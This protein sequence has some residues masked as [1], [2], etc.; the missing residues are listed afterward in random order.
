MAIELADTPKTDD[1]AAELERLIEEERQRFDVP[2]VAVAVVHGG[3]VVL[4]RGFGQRDLAKGLPVTDQT[5]FAIGSSTKAFTASLCGAL[6][7]DGLL[8]WDRPVRHYLP[9][10]R[11]HD[12]VATELLTV[13]DMLS[14][15]SGLP[16]HDMLWYGNEKLRREELVERLPHLEPN[17]T[18]R[19]LWQ[20]NNLMYVT[21]GYLAGELMGCGW[22]EAVRRRLLQPSG[23]GGTNFSVLESQQAPDHAL[24]HAPT[25]AGLVEVPFRGLDLAGPAGPL[26]PSNP[27]PARGGGGQGHR[28]G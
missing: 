25:A 7:D 20:Y 1:K 21:A 24:P 27:R 17:K 2:G 9:R 14:H 5:L 15:R 10:L 26:H 16:R 4:S 8:E 3:R 19:E 6:V 28:G 18:F 11:M 23:I 12:P 13:R 22:E